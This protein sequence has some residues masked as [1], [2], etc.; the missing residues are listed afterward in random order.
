MTWAVAQP[1]AVRAEGIADLAAAYRT[2]QVAEA[3]I[4]ATEE[5]FTLFLDDPDIGVRRAMASGLATCE[6][7]PRALIWALMNDIFAVAEPIY[8]HSAR[9]SPAE[10]SNAATSGSS[11][12]ATLIAGRSLL[13]GQVVRAIAQRGCADAVEALLNN[14]TI[15]LGSALIDELAQ[16]FADDGPIRNALLEQPQI[17]AISRHRLAAAAAA[18]MATLTIGNASRIAA[19]AADALDKATLEIASQCELDELPSYAAHLG[20]QDLITPSLL[21]RSICIG[22]AAL[23]ETMF[24]T[25]TATSLNRVQSI[26]DDSRRSAFRALCKKAALPAISLP[27]FEAALDNWT[28]CDDP[29]DMVEALLEAVEGEEVVDGALVNLLGRIA[30]ELHRNRSHRP[31]Q[32]LLTAA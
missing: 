17:S 22:N 6:R 20:D 27:L 3:D 4:E 24:A 1:S 30:S 11:A 9:L 14:C 31:K 28:L 2:D 12:I 5:V 23:F 16:R 8:A 10:L 7:V 13:D 26:M 29:M 19:I 32:L 18:D 15:I 25:A 21:V